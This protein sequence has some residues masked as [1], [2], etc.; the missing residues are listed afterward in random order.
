MALSLPYYNY[1]QGCVTMVER[2]KIYCNEILTNDNKFSTMYLI[3]EN[4][5][6]ITCTIDI[7][8]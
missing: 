5:K 2:Y 3:V 7:C 1:T 4:P 6:I 8:P